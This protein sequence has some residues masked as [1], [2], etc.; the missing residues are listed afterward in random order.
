MPLNWWLS[1][2]FWRGMAIFTEFTFKT[3][4]MT[5]FFAM[6]WANQKC[7]FEEFTKL[8]TFNLA[9]STTLKASNNF[10]IY[11]INP[12]HYS[13][14]ATCCLLI[15]VKWR[16]HSPI[17]GI[18]SIHW[19]SYSAFFSIWFLSQRISK[20]SQALGRLP[21]W[22]LGQHNMRL[23]TKL[24]LYNAMVLPYLL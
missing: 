18:R 20:A 7:L 5:S 12:K 19:F 8:C 22:V 1:N 11:H 23:S 21:N 3:I 17:T 6:I 13:I 2:L 16:P 4:L 14:S 10:T 9:S 24:K 15:R